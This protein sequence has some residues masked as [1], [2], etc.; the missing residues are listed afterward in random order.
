MPDSTTLSLEARAAG[1]GAW[2]ACVMMCRAH[3]APQ[4]GHVLVFGHEHA[5][6]RGILD[7]VG[8][9]IDNTQEITAR[10]LKFSD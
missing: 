9:N 1:E 3:G 10:S 4:K 8:Q 6:L 7:N 2:S 5:M